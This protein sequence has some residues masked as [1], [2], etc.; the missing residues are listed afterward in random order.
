M[1]VIPPALSNPRHPTVVRTPSIQPGFGAIQSTPLTKIHSVQGM[2]FGLSPIASP[3]P[4]NKIN[5]S[6]ADSTALATK[7]VKHGAP[8]TERTIPV[9]IPAQQAAATAALR[10]HMANQKT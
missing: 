3:I 6:G 10:R 8:P 4:T 9:T 2:G 7:T 1:T 5:L